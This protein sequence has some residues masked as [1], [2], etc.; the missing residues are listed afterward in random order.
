MPNQ[1]QHKMQIRS[2]LELEKIEKPVRRYQDSQRAKYQERVWLNDYQYELYN[3]AL[4]GLS[5]YSQGQLQKI[6]YHQRRKITSFHERV[7]KVLNLW[8]QQ[9]VNQ[10]FEQL[11]SIQLNKFPQNPFNT[12]F[13]HTKIGVNYFGKRTDDLFQ[14]T[15]TFE[16]LKINRKQIINK[17]IT[18]RVFPQNFFQLTKPL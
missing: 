11:C 13:Q 5:S 4:Y 10:L 2:L 9:L 16:Q 6:P 8:K 15:L 3:T 12:V 18:E 14:C 7:Q 1:L 17:L